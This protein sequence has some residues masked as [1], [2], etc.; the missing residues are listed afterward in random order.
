M[1]HLDKQSHFKFAIKQYIVGYV[2]SIIFSVIPFFVVVSG[3]FV[4]PE[5]VL[6]TSFDAGD[7]VSLEHAMGPMRSI[8]VIIILACAAVQFYIQM[9]FFMHITE[10]PNAKWNIIKVG[11]TALIT[12]IVVLGSVWIMFSLH[13][14]AGTTDVTPFSKEEIEQIKTPDYDKTVSPTGEHKVHE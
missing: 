6:P 3:Y 12:L 7:F 5:Y 2:L 1:E 4:D 13:H 14:F 10:G 9:V 11:F 8:G